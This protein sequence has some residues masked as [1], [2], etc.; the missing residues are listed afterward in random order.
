MPDIALT[1][2]PTTARRLETDQG[3]LIAGGARA[4]L[5][6]PVAAVFAIVVG[7]PIYADDVSDAAATGRFTLAAASTLV[8]FGLLALALVAIYAAQEHRLGRAAHAGFGVALIGTLL[9]AGGQWDSLFTVPYLADHAP[10]VLDRNT[11]GSL[12]AGY[13]LSYVVLTAGWISVAV[14]TLRAKVLPRGA[15]I[16]LLVGAVLAFVPAPTPIRVLVLTVGAALLGRAALR[17]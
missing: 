14:T 12:L 17:R 10:D 11:D 6:A 15:S 3:P 5:A 9:A 1:A 13:V 16:V 2:R 4:A 7:A 8:V